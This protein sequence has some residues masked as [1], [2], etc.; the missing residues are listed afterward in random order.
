MLREHATIAAK[1]MRRCTSADGSTQFVRPR[2][3]IS[4]DRHNRNTEHI[5]TA[6]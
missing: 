4:H 6:V 1:P 3:R 2:N 5:P